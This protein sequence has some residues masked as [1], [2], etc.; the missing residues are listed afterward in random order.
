MTVLLPPEAESLW[1]ASAPAAPDLPALAGDL[2]VDTVVVGAGFCGLHAALALAGAGQ[3]VAV[4]DAG[5]LGLGGSGRNGGVVSAKFRRSYRDIAASHGLDTAR[6]MHEIAQAS[7]VHLIATL[8]RF[9]LEA[10]FER[11]GALKCAHTEA[12]FAHAREEADWLRATLGERDLRVLDR[13]ETEAE[14]GSRDFCGAVLAGQGGVIQPL[15]YLRA[16]AAAVAREGVA[17]HPRTPV[18][19]LSERGAEV[20]LRVPGGTVTAGRVL[21][22]TNAYSSL[23]PATGRVRRML[24]PFRSA[25]IATEPL[26]ADL[27]AILC[28]KGRSYTET[29]R[30]MRWFRKVDGRLLF[31]GRG[32]LGAVDAPAAFTRLEAAMRRIFPALEGIAID[33]RWSGHVALTFDALPQAGKLSDRVFYAAGFNGTGVAMSGLVGHRMG[34]LIA[35]ADPELSLILRARPPEVPFFGLRAVGVRGVTAWFEMLDALGR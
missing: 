2:K 22:A 11:T 7:V 18:L 34:Q 16:L 33:K 25:M 21:L 10:G 28:P 14:T 15:R 30:M 35:G 3:S 19:D 23:T 12:A 26:P 17:V 29:R 20:Q 5:S 1:A 31:G 27:D 4:L 8:Q 6:T 9:G 24:V 13:Q 32:A